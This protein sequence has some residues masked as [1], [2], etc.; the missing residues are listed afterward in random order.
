MTSSFGER[1][2]P[3]TQK[4]RFHRG[5]DIGARSGAAIV[6]PA[7]GRVLRIAMNTRGYGNLLEIDHGNGFITRYGQLLS[8]DV[9]PEQ[10]IT[11]GQHIAKVGSTGR[12]TAP[13]LHLELI[14]DGEQI[15]P[16][17]VIDLAVPS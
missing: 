2:D 11:A 7:P 16:A 13:H 6:S 5:V 9:M 15:D 1:R 14:K 17:S 10:S 8:I 12:S 3:F 4:I